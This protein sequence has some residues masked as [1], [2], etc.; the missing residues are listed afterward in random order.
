MR[1]QLNPLHHLAGTL[2]HCISVSQPMLDGNSYF[3]FHPSRGASAEKPLRG[4]NVRV[5]ST[6]DIA[7]SLRHVRSP[8]SRADFAGV[9][10]TSVS[11]QNQT[12]R[13]LIRSPRRR[14]EQV[15]SAR[16]DQG[17][18][19]RC[20]CC[21]IN[22]GF[23]LNPTPQRALVVDFCGSVFHH[24]FGAMLK[25]GL[26]AATWAGMFTRSTTGNA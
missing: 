6:C 11:R 24:P 22:L 3:D 2:L 7:P 4:G 10:G 16:R 21:E 17:R 18:Q 8:P 9:S 23:V 26:T 19:R 5:G 13:L 12:S 25:K 1:R 14:A 15:R 20:Y